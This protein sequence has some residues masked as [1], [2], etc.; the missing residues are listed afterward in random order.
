MQ[1]DENQNP[2]AMGPA[3]SFPTPLHSAE[4]QTQ[5]QINLH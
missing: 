3:F 5:D 1:K 2:R 4:H